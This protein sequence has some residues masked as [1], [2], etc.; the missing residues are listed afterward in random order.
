MPMF[1]ISHYVDSWE[2]S[3]EAKKRR[4][5]A[6][7]LLKETIRSGDCKKALSGARA[8][9]KMSIAEAIAYD[10]LEDIVEVVR[11]WEEFCEKGGA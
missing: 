7:E 1:K 4:K 2:R 9:F 11:L 3:E 6:I 8:L 10:I 5:E